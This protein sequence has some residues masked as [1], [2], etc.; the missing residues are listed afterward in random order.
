MAITSEPSPVTASPFELIES[1]SS[2]ISSDQSTPNIQSQ[3][4][5]S[6][7]GVTREQ[8]LRMVIHELR[9][10]HVSHAVIAQNLDLNEEEVLLYLSS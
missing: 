4:V 3:S 1:P 7:D 2:P 5:I 6:G 10:A 9:A 8:Y